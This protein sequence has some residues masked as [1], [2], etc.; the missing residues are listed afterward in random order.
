MSKLTL[1][2]LQQ[3]YHCTVIL[4]DCNTMVNRG[5]NTTH[6]QITNNSICNC[7]KVYCNNTQIM[8]SLYLLVNY[9]YLF[10]LLLDFVSLAE[11][12]F[13]FDVSLSPE[14]FVLNVQYVQ[15]SVVIVDLTY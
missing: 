11:E 13:D 9:F 6:V 12:K 5:K 15:G 14:R 7:V 10:F 4:A 3:W 1:Q 2:K 8:I